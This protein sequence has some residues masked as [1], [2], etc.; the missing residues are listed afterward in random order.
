MSSKLITRNFLF[1][2]LSNVVGQLFV[3]WAYVRIAG[4]FGPAQ[5]GKFSFAQAIAL[6]FLYLGDFGLQTLGTRS[7]A[8]ERGNMSRYVWNISLLR[9]MLGIASFIILVISSF[10]LPVDDEVQLLLIIFGLALL[11]SAVLLEWVFLGI[12]RMEFV[13]LG[14]ILKG[15]VFA[16]LVFLFVGSP[17]HLSDAAVFYVAGIV[18]ATGILLGV[19]QWKFGVF[20]GRLDFRFLRGMLVSAVPL[21]AGSLII[22]INF[23]FGALALGFFLPP[24]AVGLFSAAYKI[25]LFMLAFAVVAAANAVFPLIARSYKESTTQMSETLKKFLRLF[26]IV[27]IPIGV[28]G[29]VLASQIMGFLYSEEFQIATVVFQISIWMVVI[30]IYRVVFENALIASRSQR[31]YFVGHILG[32]VVT[33][34]GNLFLVRVLDFVTPAVVGVLSESLLLCYFV[35]SC[36]FVRWSYILKMTL[37]PLLAASIMG[38]TLWL[39][40]LNLLAV[41]TIGVLMYFGLLLALRSISLDEVTGYM[42]SLVH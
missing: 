19:F 30:A 15:I 33:V 25:V 8:Q 37:K 35:G 27:A 24:E 40:P 4:V 26:V 2:F 11:P 42:Q 22:Q 29:T 38:L 34:V 3:L 21:A 5:F 13:G 9:I 28:G 20:P 7:I 18:A 23:N 32:G 12:E 10:I 16:G 1:L 36:K 6:H 31:S 14:R 41:F 17:D 39:L